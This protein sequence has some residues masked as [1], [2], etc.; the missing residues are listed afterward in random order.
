MLSRSEVGRHQLLKIIFLTATVGAIVVACLVSFFVLDNLFLR[1]ERAAA[2]WQARKPHHYIYSIKIIG[3]SFT[4]H[5][6]IEIR[7]NRI[8]RSN[9]LETGSPS[10]MWLMSP[11][12]SLHQSGLINNYILIDRIFKLIKDSRKP[13]A[14][15]LA[16]FYHLEPELYTSLVR[17]GVVS[18]KSIPC[19]P[20]FPRVT[21][22]PEYGYPE[23]L[24]LGARRCSISYEERSEILIEID[25]FQ[26]L[27]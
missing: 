23:K 12:S 27:P 16:L 17:K 24:V 18:E 5:L 1:H 7:D 14:K 20:P 4:S 3:A 22:N 26:I 15:P 10:T 19:T 2:R 6:E 9:H 8:V 21:Y 25:S 11:G 13:T